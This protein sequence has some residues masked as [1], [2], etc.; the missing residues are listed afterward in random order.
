M[1]IVFLNPSGQLGGAETALLDLLAAIRQARPSW[2]LGMIASAGGPLVERAVNLGVRCDVLPFP[3]S[4][5]R[6]GEW[7]RRGSAATRLQLGAALVGAAVPALRYASRLRRGLRGLDPDIVHTNGLKMHLLGAR[8]RPDG[9]RLVWH[10]HDYPDARPVT[11]ALL[12]TQAHRCAVALANSDSV[13]RHARKLFGDA[14]PVRTLYNSVDLDRFCPEGR[15]LDLDA[16]AGA[17]PLVPGGIR[18]GLVGTF[19]RWKGQDVFLDALSRLVVPAVAS[20]AGRPALRGYIIG[21]PIY[22]TDASQF[23]LQELRDLA[24]KFGL[25]DA[26]AFTGRIDDVPAAL[27]ALDVV[28]HASTEPEPFGLVIAEA[29]ATARP[30]VVSRAGGAAEI[31]AAGALFHSPGDAAELADRLSELIESPELRA[32]LGQAGRAAAVRLF[33]RRRLSET[34]VP[35]YEALAPERQA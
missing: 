2:S 3:Q 27:R 7:G 10:L 18:I 34:L 29:M 28:V 30:V 6:L 21:G 4:L 35:L 22:Q 14:M 33:D 20:G 17:P 25:G 5:A 8:C 32:S 19:A 9:A 15:A 16:L 24:V 23:S 26:V 11:A 31:A 1:R 13:A 12:R